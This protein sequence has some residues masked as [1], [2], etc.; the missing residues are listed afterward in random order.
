[1]YYLLTYVMRVC[2]SELHSN[3]YTLLEEFYRSDRKTAS[4]LV[5][6]PLKT[7]NKTSVY[8]IA[9]DADLTD[10]KTHDCF[11]TR[12]DRMWHGKFLKIFSSWQVGRRVL[13]LIIRPKS[14]LKTDL[15]NVDYNIQFVAVRAKPRMCMKPNFTGETK[16]VLASLLSTFIC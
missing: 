14:E 8:K 2:A 15:L 3:A 5:K 6:Q 16:N 12:L 4:K 11:Q 7:W 1:M 13:S 10:F 9:V